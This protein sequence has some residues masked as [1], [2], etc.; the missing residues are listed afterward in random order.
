MQITNLQLKTKTEWQF[1]TI[2]STCSKL[3]NDNVYYWAVLQNTNFFAASSGKVSPIILVQQGRQRTCDENNGADQL[4]C[5]SIAQISRAAV[6]FALSAFALTEVELGGVFAQCS[7]RTTLF[8]AFNGSTTTFYMR[9]TLDT[10]IRTGR[11][12]HLFLH[13]CAVTPTFGANTFVTFQTISCKK[14]IYFYFQ[15]K[16]TFTILQNKLRELLQQLQSSLGSSELEKK[17]SSEIF[18]NDSRLM[19]AN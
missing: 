4:Y 9:I 14:N 12:S 11:A 10:A 5:S 7:G 17:T 1:K 13:I 19:V 2:L 15:L 8:K 3:S 16:P 18:P 6:D